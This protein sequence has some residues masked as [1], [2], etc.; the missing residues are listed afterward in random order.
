MKK[1]MRKIAAIGAVALGAFMLTGCTTPAD[2]TNHNLDLEAE[3]FNL[4]RDIKFINGITD[5][6]LLEEIG[7]A[8]V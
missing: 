3:S 2:T 6:I 8:H 7:R 1:T 5:N 4:V